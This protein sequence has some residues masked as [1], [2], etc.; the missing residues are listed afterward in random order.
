MSHSVDTEVFNPKFRD[1]ND[2]K[3]RIGYVGRLTPEKNVRWLAQLGTKLWWPKATVNFEI[4]M[5]GEGSEGDWLRQNMQRAQFTGV[6][7]GEALSRA[8]A[9]M[10]VLAFPS[11]TETFGLVVLEA[12]ASGVPA[13]VTG[14]GGPRFTVRSGETGFVVNHL[15]EFCRLCGNFTH[16]AGAALGDAQ[17]RPGICTFNLLGSDL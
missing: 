5:V 6:L 16:S 4:V 13:V 2:E 15:D 10:D 12:L 9:N 14:A 11:F 1:Q 3:F 7:T 8:F 17:R